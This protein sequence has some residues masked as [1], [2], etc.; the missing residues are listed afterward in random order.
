MILFVVE[1]GSRDGKIISVNFLIYCL[2]AKVLA[3]ATWRGF[4]C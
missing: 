3:L 4:V 1:C 2:L